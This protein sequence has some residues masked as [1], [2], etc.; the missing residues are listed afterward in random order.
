MIDALVNEIRAEMSRAHNGGSWAKVAGFIGKSP[1][2][3]MRVVRGDLQLS[4]DA[5]DAW[6][7]NYRKQYAGRESVRICPTCGVAHV[8]GD[9]HG[10]AGEPVILAT[11]EE[12]RPV[13]VVVSRKRKSRVRRE[14]SAAQAAIWDGLTAAQRDAALGV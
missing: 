7:V 3:A 1:A 5:M 14:M 9:C 6:I 2:Y 8:V 10:K 4:D 11:G 12:L 13:R